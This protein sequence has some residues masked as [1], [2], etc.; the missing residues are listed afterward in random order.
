MIFLKGGFYG[1][2]FLVASWGVGLCG[3]IV[4]WSV[5]STGLVCCVFLLFFECLGFC[6]FW[7]FALLCL[8]LWN[9][10]DLFWVSL[11]LSM[12]LDLSRVCLFWVCLSVYCVFVYSLGLL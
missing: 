12:C 7:G 6:I 4:G 3:G 1:E 5:L 10:F 11:I 8:L 2:S 9:V